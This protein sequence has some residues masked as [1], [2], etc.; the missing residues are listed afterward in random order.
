M[1]D[2]FREKAREIAEEWR[3]VRSRVQTEEAPYWD[4]EIKIESA[5]HR[6]QEETRKEDAEIVK[7]HDWAW[8]IIDKSP[9]LMN[10]KLQKYIKR[11]LTHRQEELATVILKG[12]GKK[13]E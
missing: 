9:V 7:Q 6:I 8:A 2:R 4:L 10:K 12:G 3:P 1:K 11:A 13:H 5:L